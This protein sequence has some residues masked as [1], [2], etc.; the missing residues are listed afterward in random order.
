MGAVVSATEVASQG[1]IQIR[2]AA[3][4]KDA[5]WVGESD[6]YCVCRVGAAGSPWQEKDS[7]VE[8]RSKTVS[9]SAAPSWNL[10]FPY[11]VPKCDPPVDWELHVRVYDSDLITDDFLGE[12]RIVISNLVAKT[13]TAN[14]QVRKSER[15]GC[16]AAA[17]ASARR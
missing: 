5:D 9:D 6:P 3:G 10:A 7:K 14:E 17:G 13:N 1:S 2:G 11:V 16:A 12:A 4:L 15:A 8:R